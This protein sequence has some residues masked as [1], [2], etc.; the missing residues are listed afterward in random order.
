MTLNFLMA[1]KSYRRI[2]IYL[3]RPDMKCN[4]GFTARIDCAT[5]GR[6][7]SLH[8]GSFMRFVK[9]I[10]KNWHLYRKRSSLPKIKFSICLNKLRHLLTRIQAARFIGTPGLTLISSDYLK[11]DRIE[12]W[13]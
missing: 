10:G 4:V 3:R 1:L 7:S 6:I 9:N 8:W 13:I 12:G 11:Q 5:K 2:I